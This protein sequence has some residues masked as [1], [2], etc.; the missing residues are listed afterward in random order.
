ME[1]VYKGHITNYRAGGDGL[2]VTQYLYS[3][4]IKY[5]N[6]INNIVHGGKPVGLYPPRPREKFRLAYALQL[7]DIFFYYWHDYYAKQF[8]KINDSFADYWDWW[9]GGATPTEV[10]CIYSFGVLNPDPN[11]NGTPFR[12]I[13]EAMS[14]GPRNM[15][16]QY[17]NIAIAEADYLRRD[18]ITVYSIGLGVPAPGDPNDAYQDVLNYNNIK[19]YFLRRVAMDVQALGDPQFIGVP[20]YDDI[21]NTYAELLVNGKYKHALLA[22]QLQE[23]FVKMAAE[24]KVKLL[25]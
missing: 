20:T 24:I 16:K 19:E 23:I 8:K 10:Q 6:G 12:Y 13:N 2:W 21:Q 18:K 9:R 11:M 15:Y 25:G 1:T 5:L 7:Y 4:F 17:H 14:L 22:D 3:N